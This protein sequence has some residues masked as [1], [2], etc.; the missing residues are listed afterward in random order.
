MNVD[1]KTEKV[2]KNIYK[3]IIIWSKIN[4]KSWITNKH[5]SGLS[6]LK[7]IICDSTYDQTAIK[8]EKH[9]K[10]K[11]K[12]K[13]KVLIWMCKFVVHNTAQNNSDNLPSYT[14]DNCDWT[15]IVSWKWERIFTTTVCLNN[16]MFINIVVRK[17]YIIHHKIRYI[18]RL[19]KVKIYSLET[20]QKLSKLFSTGNPSMLVS[21]CYIL[22]LLQYIKCQRLRCVSAT[23]TSQITV[24]SGY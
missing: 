12:D 21:C 6:S 9:R 1:R 4:A 20:C 19:K 5:Y 10:N 16:R 2:I 14:P 23:C 24:Y 17:L 18:I 7:S 3:K 22:L 15:H 13:Q 8:K 11:M